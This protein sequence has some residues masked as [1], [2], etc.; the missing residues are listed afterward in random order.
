MIFTNSIV[1]KKGIIRPTIQLTILSFFN[2]VLG[3]LLQIVIAYYFGATP[4]RDSYFAAIVIPTYLTTIFTGSIGF[5][6]LPKV[7][8][9]Q[10]SCDETNIDKFLSSVIIAVSAIILFIVMTGTIFSKSILKISAPGFSDAQLVETSKLFT[11]L[12]PSVLFATLSNLFSSIFQIRSKFVRPAL[13]PLITGL[14]SLG[15]VILFTAKLGIMSLA[16]GYLTGSVISFLFLI[17]DLKGLRISFNIDFRNSAFIALF[18]LS[19]PLLIAGVL[20][21][22]TSVFERMIASKLEVGSISFLGYSFQIISIL[23]TL[24][25]GGIA[26]STFPLLSRYWISDEKKKLSDLL[27]SIL[28]VILFISIPITFVII[29]WGDILIK[30]FFERGTFTSV[31]TLSVYKALVLMTGAFIFQSL[32]NLLIKLFYI[33]GKT[34]IISLISVLELAI[35]LSL[36]YILMVRLSY[37]GLAIALSV[38]SFVN[39]CISMWYIN[40]NII[41]FDI[42]NIITGLIR[43]VLASIL[44]VFVVHFLFIH[45]FFNINCELYLV[46]CL[47]I[48]LFVYFL[49]GKVLGIV[50]VEFILNNIKNKISKC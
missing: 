24:T 14:F 38:S 33:S 49:L 43:I 35:Y 26:V 32:G 30:L 1:S 44:A 2:V 31:A 11:V 22:S 18:R 16:V 3:F 41:K 8:E 39:I 4:E 7:I 6:F 37:L 19:I 36:S 21:K 15:F 45:N 34:V 10:N 47:L 29:F 5:I 13:I 12:L 27:V 50:E 25:S 42:Y 17:S 46:L 23:A 40:K 9:L 48:G 20:S 28:R